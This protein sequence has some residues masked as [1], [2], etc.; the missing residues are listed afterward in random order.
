MDATANDVPNSK[1]DVSPLA[2]KPCYLHT[3]CCTSLHVSC[4]LALQVRGFPTIFFVSGKDGSVLEYSGDRSEDDLT[5]YIR[6]HASQAATADDHSE[7]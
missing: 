3:L 4:L 2:S 5:A 7:L 6:S 1:F